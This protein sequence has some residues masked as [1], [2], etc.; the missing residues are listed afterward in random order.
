MIMREKLC[1]LIAV[2]VFAAPLALQAASEAVVG[3]DGTLYQVRSGLYG[4]LF[5]EGAATEADDPVLALD[6]TLADGAAVRTLVEG[7]AGPETEELAALVF[8]DTSETLY[9][10][11]E[12]VQADSAHFVLAGRHGESWLPVIE[13]A[14]NV[15]PRPGSLRIGITR[16]IYLETAQ[17]N[18]DQ[19][20]E[21]TILH[22]AWWDQG[23]GE[24]VLYAPVVLLNG[25]YLGWS[26]IVTLNELD[27]Y[28]GTEVVTVPDAARAPTLERGR[29]T[30]SVVIAFTNS[31]SGQLV[32][33]EARALPG[34]LGRV[35]REVSE[36]VLE[37]GAGTL[38]IE[39][40]GDILR[41]HIVDF[42]T[43]MHPAYRDYLGT[44][45]RDRLLELIYSP[46]RP[47]VVV[48]DVAE[49]LRKDIVDL[50]STFYG[51]NGRS[52]FYDPQR[53]RFVEAYSAAPTAGETP[54]EMAHLVRLYLVQERLAPVET[55][56]SALVMVSEDGD[57]SLVCWEGEDA[58]HYQESSGEDWSEVR[59]LRLSE[60]VDQELGRQVLRDRIRG[61]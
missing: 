41:G 4:D 21:R 53:L 12:R 3:H 34:E 1:P 33:V 57:K 45:A 46:E 18:P 7:T 36:I 14:E 29:D 8:E 49:Q 35:A 38:N 42:S 25:E 9:L 5:P 48:Q 50:G 27:P 13:V 44:Q 22:L 51:A 24:R 16:D 15:N 55:G 28:D 43:D 52:R 60:G 31:A 20:V 32:S 61:H 10:A 39:T 2:L 30:N 26:P 17:A 19:A 56:D 37:E 59:T 11:W 54:G 58:L 40:L 6:T 23:D 47:G